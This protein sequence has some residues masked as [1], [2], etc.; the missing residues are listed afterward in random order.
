MNLGLGQR[1]THYRYFLRHYLC[2]RMAASSGVI[3][4]GLLGAT[5]VHAES[6]LWLSGSAYDPAAHII[7][8]L[9]IPVK[10]I[11]GIESFIQAGELTDA[12]GKKITSFEQ[13][14][15]LRDSNSKVM[16]IDQKSGRVIL[17]WESFDIG[18][19]FEVKFVQPSS[20]SLA[21]NK[22]NSSGVPSH[23]LGKLEANGGVYLVNPNGIVFGKDS[24]VNVGSLVATSLDIND[25]LFLNK[26]LSK[27]MTD[28]DKAAFFIDGS[29]RK[30]EIDGKSVEPKVLKFNDTDG[31]LAEMKVTAEN[32]KANLRGDIAILDGAQINTT[33]LNG[34]VAVAPNVLNE[35]TIKTP[36][37]QT[38]LAAAQDEAFV[39]FSTDPNLRGLLIEVNTGGD[40]NNLG[41][42]IAERGNVTLAGIAV[43]NAGTIKATTSVDFNGTIRLLAR[44][45]V[46]KASDISSLVQVSA[47]LDPKAD[48]KAIALDADGKTRYRVSTQAGDVV[49]GNH[50]AIEISPELDSKK[51][52]PDAQN[53]ALS[54]V[55][56]SGKNIELQAKDNTG[57]NNG[58]T[59]VA[60]GGR[61]F[62]EA[63]DNL[64]TAFDSSGYSYKLSDDKTQSRI[65]LGA[66]SKIDVSGV[67]V[68]LPI[69]RNVVE[70]EL[71][72][73]ELADSPLQRGGF[74]NGKKVLIDVRKGTPLADISGALASVPKQVGERLTQG[75][76]IQLR[77]SGDVIAEPD[78]TL[79]I[80]G[81]GIH[82]AAGYLATTNLISEGKVI[83]IADADPKNIYTGIL[84]KETVTN[85]RFNITETFNNFFQSSDRGEYVNAF[86]L[87]DSA[88]SIS[89]QTQAVLFNG[90]IS[91]GVFNGPDQ[92]QPKSLNHPDGGSLTIDANLQN[93]NLS[94]FSANQVAAAQL[95]N[96]VDSYKGSSNNPKGLFATDS[97][98]LSQQLFN[99]SGISHF[100]LNARNGSIEQTEKS[101]LQLVDG[102]SVSFFAADHL[103]IDGSISTS[104]GK[105]SFNTGLNKGVGE[106][107]SK[108]LPTGIVQGDLNRPITLGSKAKINTSG[109]WVNDNP[110]LFGNDKQSIAQ[111]WLDAGAV[112]L[113]AAG[114]LLLDAESAIIA[115][116]GGWINRL[117]NFV[118]GKGG[119]ISLSGKLIN[120]VQ[121]TKEVKAA[122]V[123]VNAILSSYAFS[124]GGEL[125]ITA[126]T[127][128]ISDQ[129]VTENS[130]P[131]E[132]L[133][134]DS[135]FFRRG[136]FSRYNLTAQGSNEWVSEFKFAEFV[137]LKPSAQNYSKGS[138]QFD[139]NNNSAL[140]LLPSASNLRGSLG[141]AKLPDYERKPVS[142]SFKLDDRSDFTLHSDGIRNN[143]FLVPVGV[144]ITAD[145]KA[146]LSFTSNTSLVFDGIIN[147][148]GGAVSLNTN[149]SNQNT[150]PLDFANYDDVGIWIGRNSYID[151]SSTF[152]KSPPGSDGLTAVGK[153][154]DAGSIN[155]KASRG[156]VIA[157]KGSIFDVSA[158]AY[159]TERYV[160]TDDLGIHLET[161]A[162]AA[163]AGTVLLNAA[164]GVLLDGELRAQGAGYGA[165]GGTFAMELGNSAR[166]LPDAGP[167]AFEN[168]D[169]STFSFGE[170]RIVLEQSISESLIPSTLSASDLG[171]KEAIS[172]Q[173]NGEAKFDLTKLATAGFDSYLFTPNY[174]PA[175]TAAQLILFKNPDSVLNEKLKTDAKASANVGLIKF[176]GD[177]ALVAGRSIDLNSTTIQSTNGRS[178]VVAPYIKVGFSDGIT[179]PTFLPGNASG[180]NGELV[181]AS[182]H[183]SPISDKPDQNSQQIS[184]SLLGKKT[185]DIVLS[186]NNPKADGLLNLVGNVVTQGAD[187]VTLASAGDI[188]ANGLLIST[189]ANGG[190]GDNARYLGGFSVSKNLTL[191]ADQIFPTTL[192]EFIFSSSQNSFSTKGT[193]D[194]GPLGKFSLVNE[195]QFSVEYIDKEGKLTTAV[196]PATFYEAYD[197]LAG[198][199]S[200]GDSIQRQESFVGGEK[201]VIQTI[202]AITNTRPINNATGKISVLAGGKASPVMS[203][204]GTMVFDAPS[205]EQA[206]TLKAPFGRIVFNSQGTNG[207]V[208]MSE[209]SI[210]SVASEN[211]TIP[212]GELDAAGAL[213]YSPAPTSVDLSTGSL[214]YGVRLFS[215]SPEAKVIVNAANVD[216]RKNANVNLSGGGDLFS[217]RFVPG[218]GGSKDILAAANSLQSFAILPSLS[219]QY[220]A[221]DLSIVNESATSSAHTGK[222]IGE[223]VYLSGSKDLPAGEYTLLPTRYALLPGAFLVT[224]LNDG[225]VYSSGQ[226]LRRLDGTPIVSGRFVTAN[227]GEYES[228][229]SG[230]VVEPGSIAKTRSEYVVTTANELFNNKVNENLRKNS[231]NDAAS[232]VLEA[233]KTLNLEANLI[234]KVG[235]KGLGS[236]L[237]ITSNNLLITE[238]PVAASEA[239]QVLT[240]Q[241]AGFET[242]LFGGRRTTNSD[243]TSSITAQAQHLEVGKDTLLTA[244]N[245]LLVARAENTEKK[246]SITLASGAQVYASGVYNQP[247][248][249]V[250]FYGDVFLSVSSGKQI[251]VTQKSATLGNLVLAKDSSV[252]ADKGSI[253]LLSNNETQLEGDILMQGGALTIGAGRVSLG[254]VDST[255]S[256]LKF[257]NESLAKL[258]VDQLQLTSATTIDFFGNVSI[259]L[260]DLILQAD[261]L[262]GVDIKGNTKGAA[263]LVAKQSLKLLGSTDSLTNM[264]INLGENLSP[265]LGQGSLAISANTLVLG[266]GNLSLSGFDSVTLDA[267]TAILGEDASNIRAYGNKNFT[268]TSP[269]LT[270][271][272]ASDTRIQADG[273]FNIN[274]TGSVSTQTLEKYTGLGS[275]WS[276]SGDALEFTGNAVLHS[277][278]FSLNALG[279]KGEN[280]SIRSGANIDVSGSA[281]TFDKNSVASNG[282]A[283]LLK[284][285]SGD[286][287]LESGS[288]LDISGI[289]G[290]NGSD[291]G[292]LGINALLGQVNIGGIVNAASGAESRGGSLELAVKHIT[293]FSALI[294]QATSGNFTESFSLR[295]NAGD[296]AL[297]NN[298]T[299]KAH[300]VSLT[301]DNG[302]ISIAGVIDASGDSSQITINAHNDVNL[303]STATLLASSKNNKGSQVALGTTN[304]FIRFSEGTKMDVSGGGSV[305]LR[306]PRIQNGVMIAGDQVG[307]DVAIQ[308]QGSANYYLPSAIIGAVKVDV[309]PVKI[310]DITS[311]TSEIFNT[312][313]D[314]NSTLVEKQAILTYRF[315]VPFGAICDN[316]AGCGKLIKPNSNNLTLEFF[317]EVKK[318]ERLP[319]GG[320]CGEQ[321]GCSYSYQFN[322]ASLSIAN[323]Q[324]KEFMQNASQIEQRLFGVFS[325]KDKFHVKPELE[326][327]AKNNLIVDEAIDFGEGMGLVKEIDGANT[328]A[329]DTI[330]SVWRF[331]DEL[332]SEETFDPVLFAPAFYNRYRNGESG[333]LSLRAQGSLIFNAPVSDGFA[334]AFAYGQFIATDFINGFRSELTNESNGWSYHWVSGADL[335]SANINATSGLGNLTVADDLVLRTS[336][337]AIDLVTGGDF[338]MGSHSALYT[339]GR[340]T[341]RGAF[342]NLIKD[343]F[344][345]FDFSII[346][347]AAYAADGGHIQVTV[348]KNIEASGEQQFVTDWLHRAGGQVKISDYPYGGYLPTTWAVVYEDFKQGIATLGGGDVRITASDSI[349][350]LSVFLPATGKNTSIYDKK[351]D[352]IAVAKEDSI[353]V[354]GGGDLW[355]NAGDSIA[356]GQFYVARGKAKLTAGGDIVAG[357]NGN[358]TLLELADGS[359]D[360]SAAGNIDIGAI[361]NPTVARL[362]ASQTGSNVLQSSGSSV[363]LKDYI[364]TFFT[365]AKDS[366]VTISALSGDVNFTNTLSLDKNTAAFVAGDASTSVDTQIYPA[367]LETRALQGSIIVENN[368]IT[369]F[370]SESG[371]LSLLAKNNITT[372]TKSAIN[373]PDVDPLLLPSIINPMSSV[374]E[375]PFVLVDLTQQV[376][377]KA[378]KILDPFTLMHALV[379]LYINN[380]EPVKVVAKDGDISNIRLV[381][382]TRTLISAGRDI[383]NVTFEFQNVRESDVSSVKAGR[384]IIF[385]TPR[386]LVTNT[387]DASSATQGIDIAGF[388]RLDLFAGRDIALGASRGVQSIGAQHNP[389]LV[390]NGFGEESGA[391]IN[392]F[393]GLKTAPDYLGFSDKYFGVYAPITEVTGTSQLINLALNSDL[394]KRAA[395]EHFVKSVSSVTH[396]DYFAGL[397]LQTISDAELS[398]YAALARKD[399]E[400]LAVVKQQQIAFRIANDRGDNYAGDLIELVTSERF[401]EARLEASKLLALPLAEQH[402]LALAAFKS[403]SIDAQQGLITQTYFGEVKRGGIQDASGS[404]VD[405]SKDGFVRS[406]AAIAA[407]FPVKDAA[408]VSQSYLGNISLVF[409]TLQTQQGGDL[410]LFAPGG[411]IDVGAAAVGGGVKK[412]ADKL[413]MIALRNGSVNATVNDNINVNASRVFALDGGDILLWASKGNIDAGRGAKS[414]LSVPPPVINDDG[415]VNFQAAVAG[416]GIRNSRFTQERAPGA[417]YLFAPTGV[418]NAGDAGIG[419]QGDVLIAAQQVIGAD[420]ID[421]GGVSIGIPINTGISA[422]VAGAGA[423]TNSATDA[424]AK[425]SLGGELSESL[426]QKAAAF[427][428]IDI[429][430]F[431]F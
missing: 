319:V 85:K 49:L 287:Q 206:G 118:A 12:G 394:T 211:I 114:D 406:N 237:D 108:F 56:I 407:L 277:G 194:S 163:K 69:E 143:N 50:S 255:I 402:R 253:L 281:V 61:V 151:V 98:N 384:D 201:I 48:P 411:G 176:D 265:N 227:T 124:Q 4:A 307:T 160:S 345:Q 37:G 35:G 54:G 359:F 170:R 377:P 272:G 329:D 267:K 378:T 403:A 368:G 291:A 197:V 117:G 18:K 140:S 351:N 47:L 352:R 215:Q 101:A 363:E 122:E 246:S 110:L 256:G 46:K 116:G 72:G 213:V 398:S 210:T 236:R 86:S 38:I 148:R 327:R 139:L 214:I 20:T 243:G 343:G 330:E 317:P 94:E 374:P 264:D 186:L 180:G 269:L 130:F 271:A 296:L 135:G 234:T 127:I 31:Q 310:Y 393:A 240:A 134:L 276:M 53:Q 220:S 280:L 427:V 158:S 83:N 324:T 79:N 274:S 113:K 65:T 3:L 162:Q 375:K 208:V 242:I 161:T 95:L 88:G 157:E 55:E 365:Y 121:S 325:L 22:I 362:S 34:V 418:V 138:Y 251:N 306:A 25:D 100:N 147:A 24:Q 315:P 341:G 367:Q 136:G 356:S 123:R 30:L 405:K 219:G 297:Q 385:A 67:E 39:L 8:N 279:N 344:D 182:T 195:I 63:T 27:A 404:I 68:D 382:P 7:N 21:L 32:N 430:G 58:A 383:N 305:I 268:I 172:D 177:L 314:G 156:F 19:D 175:V 179:H 361:V 187:N 247:T 347:N 115:N 380:T 422:S 224:P 292:K 51:A 232:L 205:I 212:F 190:K 387:V 241:L 111:L 262:R 386:N 238:K 396:R 285:I 209:G 379:P 126:P 313:A 421:V 395:A 288:K 154:V 132:T 77:S 229:F 28:D 428:T 60:K 91:A 369:L 254:E 203:A 335:A 286:V 17:N 2:N 15:Q 424:A 76:S 1:K 263:I 44:D 169:F 419:S 309:N 328:V 258:K 261:G 413:G 82:Y 409:S 399:F 81:G 74:L 390:K 249:D 36:D 312:A 103:T 350:N 62:L 410:N 376:D 230:F 391:D 42:I 284:S 304:G 78:T 332:V 294:K 5:A 320:L 145:P 316:D 171:K 174:T 216:L 337:G 14:N 414:A 207:A 429:L 73:N 339:A 41:K 218:P 33:T 150:Q 178:L 196:K 106:S 250:T 412:S 107:D 354:Q 26:S 260:S 184:M 420:N 70:V 392:A 235:E 301:T 104:G 129:P 340:A 84:G 326:L 29:L 43:K 155:L 416:S 202:T 185:T 40:V 389:N 331:N 415:S 239:V 299:L 109:V 366:N 233:G 252:R 336:T 198:K 57:K 80:A 66:G 349:K 266:Q 342:D 283:V 290:A 259:N 99:K 295:V 152:V 245:I 159:F 183:L 141:L 87:G 6:R 228:Q 191:Q 153:V 311:A 300:N 298:E 381:T 222:S 275:R 425:D 188:R 13:F 89:L 231:P 388:G 144:R 120:S 133:L 149:D 204:A 193:L 244:P 96:I 125:S 257:T 270:G 431:D 353:L 90:N 11:E 142:L 165:L 346:S 302:S 199:L 293:D 322:D 71:R 334:Q 338:L 75:G 426:D 372:T 97:L 102:A 364:T 357:G 59:I 423:S 226:Q 348:G 303:L 146:N 371:K 181:L 401:G 192:S 333:V 45:S 323:V 282:G 93:I 64:S 358:A 167:G 321:S 131:K 200:I 189:T 105:V 273:L 119:D 221:Y 318:G 166:T 164:E 408:D 355:I 128:V 173:L 400:S 10:G 16:R 370:P 23:I 373:L 9:P 112:S 92:R 278:E 417:V 223:K 168:Y 52:A 397:K 137:D 217:Y 360:I 289:S 225:Q 308:L 248:D